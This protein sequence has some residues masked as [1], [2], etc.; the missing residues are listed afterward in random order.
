MGLAAP[1]LSILIRDL[2][3]QG[4]LSP[5]GSKKTQAGRTAELVG[6]DPGFASAVAVE[7]SVGGIR[8]AVVD[9][10]GRPVEIVDAGGGF[11]SADAVV[12]AL[13]SVV[14]RLVKLCPERPAGIGLG[15]AGL[16]SSD[17]GGIGEF[18]RLPDW[19]E[20]RL[21]EQ[22]AAEYGVPVHIANKAHCAAL[23]ELRRGAGMGA[24]NFVY[25]HVLNGVAMGIVI[26]GK[27]YLGSSRKAGEFGH[28]LVGESGEM[29]Y[30][31]NYGCLE[32]V[33][34]PRAVLA[35]AKAAVARGVRTSLTDRGEADALTFGDVLEASEKGDRV[36]VNLVE[37]A[38]QLIGQGLSD[39]VNILDPELVIFGG[40]LSGDH[41]VLGESV[42]KVFDNRVLPAVRDSVRIDAAALGV[43][44]ALVGAG[45]LVF[46]SLLGMD[47]SDRTE[48]AWLAQSARKGPGVGVSESASG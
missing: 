41:P 19:Q 48:S 12:E 43:D 1:T 22:L 21:G 29:C 16:V 35:E 34:A 24:D 28:V 15:V 23:A 39:V 3:A 7:V 30:C 33:A 32:G 46:E 37:R 25:L 18:P 36:A 2:G 31:G 4:L 13:R 27:L 9:L 20:I 45:E 5:C 8:G 10:G 11:D 40:L 47:G 6:I 17:G 38:G 44:S 14:G 42:V 26:G